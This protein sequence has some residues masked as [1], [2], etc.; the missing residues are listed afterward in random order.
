MKPQQPVPLRWD[1]GANS[2]RV[3]IPWEI[4]WGEESQSPFLSAKKG[5]FFGRK[6]VRGMDSESGMGDAD[7]DRQ[8]KRLIVIM[9]RHH[10][11]SR[12]RSKEER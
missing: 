2:S 4:R 12:T 11:K 1:A 9:M 7:M 5:L 10:G 8:R 6:G 3:R